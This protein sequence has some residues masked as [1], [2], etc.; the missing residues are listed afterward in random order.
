MALSALLLGWSLIDISGFDFSSLIDKLSKETI[1]YRMILSYKRYKHYHAV[2][3][4]GKSKFVIDPLRD[5][6]IL[7]NKIKDKIRYIEALL[8]VEKR[9]QI[10]LQEDI[11]G[12]KSI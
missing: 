3:W 9:K 1:S 10:F 11:A 5:K 12:F 4:D 7:L 8:P 6:L 2:A